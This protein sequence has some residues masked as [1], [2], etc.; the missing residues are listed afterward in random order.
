M[1]RADLTL[2]EGLPRAASRLWKTHGVARVGL[3]PAL[4]RRQRRRVRRV[5]RARGSPLT[6]GSEPYHGFT[7]LELLIVTVV[8]GTLASMVA[9]SLQDAREKARV[10]RAIADIRTVAGELTVYTMDN[11][12]PPVNL[13][14]IG[15]AGMLDPYGNTYEYLQINTG[16][17][18]GGGASSGGRKDKFLVP[19]NSDFDLYSK[20][21]DG[22]SMKPLSS[23][24][25]QDD[26]L[27]ALDGAFIGLAENF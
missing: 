24:V 11:F 4:K 9:P 17:S 8:L 20:G 12:L 22:E 13:A 21:L 2:K 27:R 3:E 10:A 26:I 15:R 5:R 18:K 16:T 25:S 7:L 23:K 6:R 19:L 14:V 1:Y